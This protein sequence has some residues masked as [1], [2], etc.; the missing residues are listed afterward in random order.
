[1]LHRSE[2]CIVYYADMALCEWEHAKVNW[3]E[4]ACGSVR[5]HDMHQHTWVRKFPKDNRE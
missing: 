5:S 1:M 4:V 3:A 2:K